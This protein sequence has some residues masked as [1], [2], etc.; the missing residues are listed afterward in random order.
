MLVR[1]YKYLIGLK[2]STVFFL[3]HTLYGVCMFS[4]SISIS[5]CSA[6]LCSPA[7]GQQQLH[8]VRTQVDPTV[9]QYDSTTVRSTYRGAQ[10]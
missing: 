3:S 9:P 7:A 6:V 8:M 4:I 5:I 1:I 2:H 10:V